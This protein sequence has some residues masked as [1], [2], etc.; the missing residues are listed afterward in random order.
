MKSVVLASSI[1]PTIIMM[2]ISNDYT[3]KQRHK[4]QHQAFPIDVA[5]IH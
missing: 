5:G 1:L 2:Y 4:K 3:R